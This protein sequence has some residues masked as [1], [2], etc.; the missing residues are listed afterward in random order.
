[1][2]TKQ[3]LI[4]FFSAQNFAI[5]VKCGPKFCKNHLFNSK[6]K[7]KK[8][9]KTRTRTFILYGFDSWSFLLSTNLCGTNTKERCNCSVISIEL[10]SSKIASWKIS[11][12]SKDVSSSW[13]FL[14]F[15]LYSPQI[16]IVSCFAFSVNSLSCCFF[17]HSPP[18]E[19]NLH[20]MTL[21]SA[22]Q[23]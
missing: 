4:N 10:C 8:K 13:K 7:K 11:T 2:K 12:V 6:K 3:I 17:N 23:Q 18:I 5:F 19:G 1:M 20:I 16:T 21:P 14:V 9:K 22:K 15:L